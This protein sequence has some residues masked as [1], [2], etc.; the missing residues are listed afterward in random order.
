MNAIDLLCDVIAQGTMASAA[1][2]W[3]V[4]GYDRLVQHGYLQEAGI[5]SSVLCAQC[6]T[7][8]DAEIV[9]EGDRYG[10]FCPDL[11]F[12]PIELN[13]LTGLSPN[14]PLLVDRLADCFSRKRSKATPVHGQ[15]WRIGAVETDHGDA[16]LYFHPRLQGGDDA[17]RLTEALGREVRSPWQLVVTAIGWLPVGQVVIITLS[18]LVELDVEDG[19][20]IPIIDLHAVFGIPQRRSGGRPSHFG[21]RLKVLIQDRITKGNALPG[22]NEEAKAVLALFEKDNPGGK[23]PSLS[24]VKEYVTRVRSGSF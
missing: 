5:I 2:Y 11:G 8:H 4:N 12:I 10:Y 24:S 20:L 19:V 18:D 9:F 15:T 16:V 17:C 21:R 1:S 3:S 7:P 6:H 13:G 22:R 23:P 14:L